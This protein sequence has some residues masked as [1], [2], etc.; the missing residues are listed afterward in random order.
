MGVNAVSMIKKS[1]E[2]TTLQ[3]VLAA[4]TILLAKYAGAGLTIAGLEF[5]PMTAT[6][7]GVAFAAVTAVW[8][9]REWRS[10]KFKDNVSI[11]NL[12]SQ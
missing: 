9:Q 6:E 11:E 8:L 7:F 5:P 4:N 12:L 2:S 10:A 3:F 1:R